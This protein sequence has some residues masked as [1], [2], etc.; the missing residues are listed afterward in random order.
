MKC[1][2]VEYM[3]KQAIKN[4]IKRIL[5]GS[6]LKRFFDFTTYPRVSV[7]ASTGYNNIIGNPDNII[8]EGNSTLKRDSVIMNGRA[9]FTIKNNSG[10]AEELMVITGNHM[11]IVG[12]SVKDVTDSVKDKEDGLKEYDKDVTVDEDVWMGARVT[13][14]S[15]VHIGRGA[16]IGTGTVVR[17][18][19]P[20]Y[21]VVIGNPAKIVGFRFTPEEIMEHEK[22]LYKEEERLPLSL[23]E[24]NYE[25]Y[26]LSKIKEIRAYLSLSC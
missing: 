1:K 18:S 25:K 20:P 17:K 8:M 22:V 24:K 12:K 19:V 4:W 26:F 3:I 2:K 15:G 23:L 11:S 16:E 9:K 5:Y 14:L 10:A 21:A 7:K 6:G 13:L